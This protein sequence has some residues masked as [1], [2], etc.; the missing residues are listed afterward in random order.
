MPHLLV[1]VVRVESTSGSESVISFPRKAPRPI[2]RCRTPSPAARSARPRRF[3]RLSTS[4]QR[5]WAIDDQEDTGSCVGWAT[6]EGVV[7]YHMVNVTGPRR[8]SKGRHIV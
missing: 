2:T 1:G 5:L 3:H 6:A 4:A 8:S 7:R